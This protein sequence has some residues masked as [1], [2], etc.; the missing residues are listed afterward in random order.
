[1]FP[2][3]VPGAELKVRCVTEILGLVTK[4]ISLWDSFHCPLQHPPP[5]PS[6]KQNK[7]KTKQVVMDTGPCSLQPT[8]RWQLLTCPSESP[9][10]CG[11]RC[12]AVG[13][14]AASLA[15]APLPRS[16]AKPA[17]ARVHTDV[18]VGSP[19]AQQTT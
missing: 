3:L 2:V 18:D 1:M 19:R 13:A 6:P 12:P 5:P 8:G 11:P 17:K 10:P 14:G 7:I 9:G 4:P 15:P 16:V